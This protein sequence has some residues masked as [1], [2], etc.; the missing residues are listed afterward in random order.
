VCGA[1][2]TFFRAPRPAPQPFRIR[3]RVV[4][5]DE[6]GARYGAVE[7]TLGRLLRGQRVPTFHIM[8]R[9]PM[10]SALLVLLLSACTGVPLGAQATLEIRGT[11][12]ATRSASATFEFERPDVLLLMVQTTWGDGGYLGVQMRRIG[13]S[14]LKP[15]TYS[16][17][18]WWGPK[19]D[20][21]E[22]NALVQSEL[23]ADSANRCGR[24]WSSRQGQVEVTSADTAVTRGRFSF[25]A[26]RE[27]L[28]DAAKSESV[29][30]QG[31]FEAKYDSIP[32]VMREYMFKRP[33]PHP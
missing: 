30:V 14:F 17:A 2:R 27:C 22:F 13:Q 19:P 5:W 32:V 29:W 18:D 9:F 6:G 28:D 12:N 26:A 15:G 16:V 21:T 33:E 31:T 3:L 10:R 8:H 23:H 20:T 7:F 11:S 1:R 24:S 4:Q 25:I